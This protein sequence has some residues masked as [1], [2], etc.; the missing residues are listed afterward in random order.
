MVLSLL[1]LLFVA[2]FL[3]FLCR[4]FLEGEKWTAQPYNGHLSTENMGLVK[5]RTGAIL[6]ET[7]DGVRMYHEDEATRRA[8]LHTVGDPKEYISTS[9]QASMRAKL[10]GYHLLTGVG[11]TPLNMLANNVKLTVDAQLTAVAYQAMGDKNGTVMVYNYHTGEMLCKVSKPTFDPMNMPEDLMENP[12]YEGVFLDKNLSAAYTPGSTFKII[13]QAAAMDKWPDQ[14]QSRTYICNGW[15]DVG[16]SEITCMGTH[17]EVDAY[18]AFGNSCNVYYALLANDLGSDILQQKAEGM[19]FNQ[20]LSFEG[21]PCVKSELD[22][23]T[24]S[25]NELGWAGVGQHTT[26]ANPYHMLTLMG[27]IANGGTY[28]APKVM[29]GWSLTDALSSGSRGYLDSKQAASLK[30]LMRSNVQNY[31]GDYFPVDMMVC[32]KSGTAEVGS[33]KGDNSWMVGF[34]AADDYPYAVVV[35]VEEGVS[36]AAS[37][38]PVMNAVLTQL[39]Q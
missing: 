2:G 24:V 11:D 9:V 30:D 39:H 6:A 36:G 19:G 29:D 4:Y 17:G 18:A 34:C 20:N 38:G 26:L 25:A 3:W 1:V 23:A 37:A 32:A 13:T 7:R 27:A 33:D 35:V 14:W 16:G 28:Q 31:Y 10:N 22:L 5:D 12:A 8:L 15:V 21:I